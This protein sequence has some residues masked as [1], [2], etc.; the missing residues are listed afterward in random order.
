MGYNDCTDKRVVCPQCMQICKTKGGLQTHLRSCKYIGVHQFDVV[1]TNQSESNR[2]NNEEA[3][4]KGFDFFFEGN[5][6]EDQEGQHCPS[7]AGVFTVDEDLEDR[8][9]YLTP[10]Q[11]VYVS[12]L[13]HL[14]VR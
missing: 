14:R 13:H 5:N 10:E 1:N 3:G 11:E 7:N 6:E 2:N 8:G 9:I 4:D 12:L